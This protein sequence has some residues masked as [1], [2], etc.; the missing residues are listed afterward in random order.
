MPNASANWICDR[1]EQQRRG[2]PLTFPRHSPRCRFRQ[3]L[4]AQD[5]AEAE[6]DPTTG[7]LRL[8]FHAT[9]AYNYYGV[10]RALYD[11]ICSAAAPAKFFLQHIKGKF[12][13]EKV[14]EAP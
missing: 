2:L 4:A 12:A 9:G 8:T 6:Y 1:C 13:W 11:G 3:E 14:K 5:I 10:T 7:T